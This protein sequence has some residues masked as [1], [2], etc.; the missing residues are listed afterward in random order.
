MKIKIFQIDYSLDIWHVY[1]R[2]YLHLMSTIGSIQSAIYRHVFE[3]NIPGETLSEIYKYL[4]TKSS[5]NCAEIKLSVSD[6]VYVMESSV[7]PQGFYY[8]DVYGFQQI[9]FNECEVNNN[10]DTIRA[11]IFEPRKIAK[12]VDIDRS[13]EGLKKTLGGSF[14]IQQTLEN[15]VCLLVRNAGD[16]PALSL[17]RTIKSKPHK[18]YMRYSDMVSLFQTVEQIGEEHLIGY[19]VFSQESF[20][21]YCSQQ[22]RT[23]RVSSRNNA[24][25]PNS[26][27]N[28]IYAT[29]LSVPA[30]AIRID[31]HLYS[32][33][34]AE[35]HWE[36]EYCFVL[37][38]SR[39]IVSIIAGPCI[40][41]GRNAQ[42][43][44]SLSV[45]QQEK[46]L[47]MFRYPELFVN[48]EQMLLSVPYHPRP[49]L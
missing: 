33:I 47:N 28:L 29:P 32:E 34:D 44:V 35:G 43:F 13:I 24:F 46:Y 15:N 37:N 42:E 38:N 5:D 1:S 18:Q 12:V 16:G 20:P 26:T 25:L 41:C 30:H 36:I 40:L 19:I 6:V 17:N 48:Y 49:Y 23:Y 39:N 31:H 2:S 22:S 45:N 8:C 4:S 7:T 11:I 3:G 9:E 27:N 14:K 10:R 21:Y